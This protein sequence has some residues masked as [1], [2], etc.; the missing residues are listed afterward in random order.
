MTKGE[1]AKEY[2]EKGLACSQA[3]ALAFK[4]ELGIGELEIK[5]IMIGFGGGFARQR[6]VCGAISGLTFVLSYLL[7]DGQDKL[8]IYSIIQ[9]ACKDVKDQVGS[10][11]CGELLS[12][13]IEVNTNPRPDDRTVEYYKKRPCGDLVKLIADVAQKHLELNKK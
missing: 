8:S 11:I 13:K 9:D 10:L 2:F 7:S 4:D 12:G 3:V 6:L 5:K 1:L